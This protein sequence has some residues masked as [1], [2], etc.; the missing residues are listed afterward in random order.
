VPY[1]DLPVVPAPEGPALLELWL[2]DGD[3][4]RW[5]RAVYVKVW[6]G[7]M[8]GAVLLAAGYVAFVPVILCALWAWNDIR[9]R[10]GSRILLSVADGRLYV[11]R[12]GEK[13]PKDLALS[14]VSEVSLDSKSTSKNMTMARA[15]GVNSVFGM[16][17]SHNID[18]DVSR[19]E[20]VPSKG[21]PI[22]LDEDYISG[23]LATDAMRR[24]RLFLRAHGWKPEDERKELALPL[25]LEST[26]F[27]MT[28][29]EAP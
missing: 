2:K 7:I 21:E 5:L 27:D 12:K 29:D 20:I 19:I 26:S 23:T 16:G 17:S 10:N 22:L 24:V 6:F 11:R 1:R 13:T 14:E 18:V 4:K 8:G 9:Q 3:S 25:D 15:D 28:R